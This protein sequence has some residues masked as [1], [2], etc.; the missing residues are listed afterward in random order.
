[1]I[2]I[3]L[4]SVFQGLKYVL[5]MMIQQKPGSIINTSSVAGTVG[6][7]GLAAYS[8]SKHAIIGLTRTATG[9]VGRQ[10]VRVNVICPG[11]IDTRMIHSLEAMISPDHPDAVAASNKARNLMGRYGQPDEVARMVVFL[12]SEAASYMN[13]GVYLIDGGRTTI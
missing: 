7:L 4:K 1:M 12:A 5:P 8:A 9:E 13:G 11:P 10:G 2:A 6:A 3:N